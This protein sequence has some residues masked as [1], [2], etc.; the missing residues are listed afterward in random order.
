M[1]LLTVPLV[2]HDAEDSAKVSNEWKSHV[3]SQFQSSWTNKCSGAVI[4]SSVSCDTNTGI[5]WLKGYGVPCFTCLDLANKMV[6]LTVSSV[7]GDACTGANSIT[8]PKESHHT[9]FQLFS[10][11]E[12]MISLMIQLASH[13]SN[14]GTNV[15]T[16]LKKECFNYGP[17]ECN[18]AI[19]HTSGFTKIYL[20]IV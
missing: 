5:T 16:W 1:V 4:M 2:S 19:D 7:P 8:W 14:A 11:N 18:V 12:Q 6:P 13:G 3:A 17:K 9:L 20:D 10:P 15:S